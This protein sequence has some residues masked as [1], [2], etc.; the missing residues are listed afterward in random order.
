[1]VLT[2]TQSDLLR[3]AY[4]QL[5]SAQREFN[6][7][8]TAIAGSGGWNYDPRTGELTTA[9]ELGEHTNDEVE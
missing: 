2:Q 9:E 7:I 6:M 8:A 3:A 1:M 5:S 4:E